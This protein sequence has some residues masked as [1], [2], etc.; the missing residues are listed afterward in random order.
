MS[1]R[2]ALFVTFVTVIG[3]AGC[4]ELPVARSGLPQERVVSRLSRSPEP[5]ARA[6]I[7]NAFATSREGLPEPFNRMTATELMP[8]R[9]QP[10]W[11]ATTVDPGGFLDE[12]KGRPPAERARGVLIEDPIGD[13]YWQSE[14]ENQV[15]SLRFRCGFIVHFIDRQTAGTEI[16][17][18]E[19]V[20]TVW[21]GEHW[22]MAAHGIGFGRYHDIRFVEP[23]T[24][25]RED[26]VSLLERIAA[27]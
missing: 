16:Q 18:F 10:D 3:L 19:V 24:K 14:Y 4:G 13:V 6:A 23:T 7:L 2:P 9:F 27:R 12:Y 20:P 1:R 21:V 8:P 25:D 17:V 5:A 11:L 26:L 22:A 15:G